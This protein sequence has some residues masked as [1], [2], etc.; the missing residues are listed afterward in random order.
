MT[1]PVPKHLWNQFFRAQFEATFG[2]TVGTAGWNIGGNGGGATGF[3]DLAVLPNS[4][5]ITPTEMQNFL[6]NAAGKRALNQQAPVAGQ[7]ETTGSFEMPFVPEL[8]YPIFRSVMG[9]VANVETAGAAALASTAFA[10]VATLD[11][12]PN[13]TEVLKFVIASSTAAS[14]AAINII[15]SAV[16]VETITIGT[17]ATSVDGDY[18]SKGAYD[19]TSNAITF[20]VDGTVT[21][22]TVVISGVDYVTNTFTMATTN[23]TMK[24]EEAGQPKS[25]SN[26]GYYAGTAFKDFEL[27]FDKTALDGLVMVTTNFSSKFFAAATATTYDNDVAT[28]Y[29]PFSGWTVT[30]TKGGSAFDKV[31]TLAL[32]VDGGTEHFRVASGDQDVAGL[33]YG[34]QQV[35][36]AL[37]ILPEDATEWNAFV[38]Q[39]VGDYHIILTSPNNIV[40]STKW[41]TTIELTKAYIETYA[42]AT[43]NQEF[44]A[45]V[46]MRTIED[47][48][49]G[50]IKITHVSR[51]PV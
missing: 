36:L 38:G 49:D 15:Q 29:H 17:S 16:T 23:P 7:Y 8:I 43:S 41:T 10:S 20:S 25:A 46:A 9:G 32:T 13:G 42:E 48:S 30:L 27:S 34:P 11:T 1:A 51:M 33:S 21:A 24:I 44:S 28:Y 2:G 31:Q 3:R 37:S 6:E 22:G 45:D 4:V 39:T 26:S 35:T 19:G 12:Q 5:R 40:D 14:A 47:S 18:Y 50:I